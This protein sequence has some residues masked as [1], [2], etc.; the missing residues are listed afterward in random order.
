MT[1]FKLRSTGFKN[2]ANLNENHMQHIKLYVKFRDDYNEM[3]IDVRNLNNNLSLPSLG[4]IHPYY[5]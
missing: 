3:N 4:T 2:D 5:Y 1:C